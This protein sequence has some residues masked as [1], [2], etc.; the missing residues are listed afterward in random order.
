MYLVTEE[1]R[2]FQNSVG[3]HVPLLHIV[4]SHHTDGDHNSADD[5]DVDCVDD[6]EDDLD[7]SQCVVSADS[8]SNPCQQEKPVHL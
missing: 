7:P 2:H 6:G 3:N 1:P 4:I 8:W 5:I